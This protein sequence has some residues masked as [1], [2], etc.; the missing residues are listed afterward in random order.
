MKYILP[1]VF[2]IVA[3]LNVASQNATEKGSLGYW[4]KTVTK[5]L[6]MPLVA[7]LYLTF[8]S[9]VEPLLLL[10]FGFGWLGDIALMLHLNIHKGAKLQS[11]EKMDILPV[12][13]G[14]LFFL[15]GH[16]TY[17]FLFSKEAASIS[18]HLLL[19]AGVYIVYLLYAAFIF[20]YLSSHGL[21]ASDQMSAKIKLVLK[22]GIG[23]Y[24]LAITLMSFMALLR[25]I[26][27]WNWAGLICY[28]GSL[29]FI[30]SDSVLSI[31]LLGQNPKMSEKYIMGSYIVAQTFIM[32][33]YIR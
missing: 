25:C 27:D 33:S 7:G 3:V 30:S 10:A 15:C 23:T 24:M 5:P 22:L 31:S 4:I 17:I 6:L 1:L 32:I 20:R 2:L 14:M 9:R 28:L 12:L 26:G 13:L 18:S 19:Y 21:L 8:T 11:T 16:V 29:I